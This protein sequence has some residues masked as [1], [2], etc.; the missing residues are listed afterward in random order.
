MLRFALS[1][2]SVIALGALAAGLL[3]VTVPLRS[4]DPQPAFLGTAVSEAVELWSHPESIPAALSQGFDNALSAVVPGV[5]PRDPA[6]KVATVLLNQDV[7][8]LDGNQQAWRE[9]PKGTNVQILASRGRF[10]Q[11]RPANGDVITVPRSV[12]QAGIAKTN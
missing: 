11:I 9:L 4:G 2:L 6:Q 7:S 8:V 10:L 5:A 3:H 12:I 1:T